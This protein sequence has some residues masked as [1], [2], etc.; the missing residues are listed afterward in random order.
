MDGI[1]YPPAS[2]SGRND[3]L[4]M[5]AK[6]LDLIKILISSVSGVFI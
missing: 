2:A 5:S 1:F 4:H 6:V 3:H